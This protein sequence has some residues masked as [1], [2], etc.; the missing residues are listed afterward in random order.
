MKTICCDV[1]ENPIGVFL[2]Q[3]LADEFIALLGE[4]QPF[5][6]MIACVNHVVTMLG[7]VEHP[8]R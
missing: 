3:H 6:R 8:E 1:G 2:S 4:A 7:L 5:H